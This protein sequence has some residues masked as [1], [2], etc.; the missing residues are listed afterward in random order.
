MS[1]FEAN[2]E[3]LEQLAEIFEKT[4]EY[5]EELE[6]K[7]QEKDEAQFRLQN[8]EHLDK[9][10]SYGFSEEEL[11]GLKPETLEKISGVVG[12]TEEPAWEIGT[13]IGVAEDSLD[14]IAR[15]CLN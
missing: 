4:A 7:I 8:S 14:P 15:F 9:L 13:G 1:A 5:V 3:M 11:S 12:S 6:A 10:A 2:P